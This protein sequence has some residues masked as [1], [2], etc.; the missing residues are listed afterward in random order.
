VLQFLFSTGGFVCTV[1]SIWATVCERRT[2][3]RAQW[4]FAPEVV[5]THYPA[6]AVDR[7]AVRDA[8]VALTCC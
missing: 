4:E 3:V 2:V 1:L 5:L 6:S 8:L 7:R